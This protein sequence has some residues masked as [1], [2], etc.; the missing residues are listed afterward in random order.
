MLLFDLARPT[1]PNKLRKRTKKGPVS[2]LPNRN[3]A[4][5]PT[6]LGGCLDIVGDQDSTNRASDWL[7]G[8]SGNGANCQRKQM[9]LLQIGDQF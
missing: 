3:S 4:K 7:I 2:Y 5:N 9:K 8:N 1:E 6:I